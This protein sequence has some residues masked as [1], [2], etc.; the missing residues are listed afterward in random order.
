MI[1]NVEVIVEMCLIFND[2]TYK[3]KNL[4]QK[5]IT[6][7]H[8]FVFYIYYITAIGRYLLLKNTSV[9]FHD[10]EKGRL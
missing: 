4:T 6:I 7:I 3:K 1:M 9:L 5:Y 10:K 8:L 2:C